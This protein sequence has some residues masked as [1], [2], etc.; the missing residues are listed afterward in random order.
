MSNEDSLAMD[1]PFVNGVPGH[2]L[3]LAYRVCG[4]VHS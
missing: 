1:I 3:V 4:V 2:R